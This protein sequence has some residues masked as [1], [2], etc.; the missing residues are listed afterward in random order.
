[1]DT[2]T[3]TPTASTEIRSAK[4]MLKALRAAFPVFAE[5]KPLAIGI[6]KQ[7][8][9]ARPEFAK[10]LLRPAMGF[11][12][13]SIPYLKAMQS[14]S[15]RFNLDGTPSDAVTDEQRDH[16]AQLLREHFRAGA[17]KRRAEKAAAEAAAAEQERARKLAAL[18]DKFGRK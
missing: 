12:T 14:A 17:E 4:E 18:A 2:T 11:H 13:R 7:V 16:A 8:M 10:K 3:P 1:M 6:D 5:F 15:N 9:A